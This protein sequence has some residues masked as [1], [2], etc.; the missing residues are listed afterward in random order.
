[1]QSDARLQVG[2]TVQLDALGPLFSGDYY[3]TD[4]SIRFDLEH[5]MRT[6]FCAER[7]GLGRAT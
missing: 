7:P 6:H 1:A 2:A 3:V 5:G 4:A